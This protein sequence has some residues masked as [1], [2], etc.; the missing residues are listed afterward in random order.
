MYST[1]FHVTFLSVS[2][3]GRFGES[4]PIP[5]RFR[6]FLSAVFLTAEYFRNCELQLHMFNGRISGELSNRGQPKISARD[7]HDPFRRTAV[8]NDKNIC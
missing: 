8:K 5:G 2:A 3:S 4:F 7:T 1:L 6:F